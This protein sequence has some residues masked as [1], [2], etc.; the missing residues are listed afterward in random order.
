M[1]AEN[2]RRITAQ[3]LEKLVSPAALKTIVRANLGQDAI[4]YQFGHDHFHYDNNAFQAADAYLDQMRRAVLDALVRVEALP[5]WQAFGRMLHTAQDFY[6]HSNYITLWRERHPKAAPDQT[7]PLLA[8][9]LTDSRLCSGRLYY[10]LEFLSFVP[11]LSGIVLPWIPRD[12]H[13]WMNKDDPSRPDFDFAYAAA[14]KRTAL[15][16]QNIIQALTPAQ[17]A[18]FTGQSIQ[19]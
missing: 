3:A 4:R 1:N 16:F 9:A 13:A 12:S 14:V 5:A 10:P 7:H 18:L 15:E 2:H 8:E 11:I 19:S 17:F 6:A